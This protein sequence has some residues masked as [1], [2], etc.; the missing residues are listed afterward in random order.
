MTKK[1][2]LEPDFNTLSFEDALEKLEDLVGQM[3]EGNLPLDKMLSCFE[4]G[5]KLTAFCRKKLEK[6]EKRIEILTSD[7]GR[8]GEWA[9]CDE[10]SARRQTSAPSSQPPEA[11]SQDTLF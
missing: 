11:S 5:M 7:D 10:S 8:A 4:Q 6:L 3:E 2:V 9:E 1:A